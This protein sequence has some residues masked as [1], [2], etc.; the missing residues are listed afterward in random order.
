MQEKDSEVGRVARQPSNSWGHR[1]GMATIDKSQ[2]PLAQVRQCCTRQH[3]PQASFLSFHHLYF[4]LPVFLSPSLSPHL[5][6]PIRF[7]FLWLFIPLSSGWLLTFNVLC[8]GSFKEFEQRG[9]QVC[10]ALA[11]VKIRNPWGFSK[12]LKNIKGRCFSKGRDYV[13]AL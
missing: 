5:D 9:G 12:L 7:L 8:P 11:E 3:F 2:S 1:R 4:V 10:V 13:E 6:F